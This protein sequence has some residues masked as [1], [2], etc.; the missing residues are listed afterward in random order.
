VARQQRR[1]EGEEGAEVG[2]Q[3]DVHVGDDGGVAGAP[4]GP[5]GAPAAL[6]LQ[7]AG[8]DAGERVGQLAGHR[9]GGVGGGV[10]DHGDAPG[11]GEALVEVAVQAADAGRQHV[12]LVVHGHH[13][14]DER[15]GGSIGGGR[16]GPGPA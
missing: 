4:G 9:A 14:V 11:E 5:Q 3:V 12:G 2:G 15:R 10:V 6:L 7:A 8:G 16:P 13:D 1:H